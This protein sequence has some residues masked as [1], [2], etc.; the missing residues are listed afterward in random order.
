MAEW[1]AR[2]KAQYGKGKTRQVVNRAIRAES[3]G[4]DETL[5]AL[6]HFS[7]MSV[8]LRSQRREGVANIQQMV[9][10]VGVVL[11]RLNAIRDEM[12]ESIK[13]KYEHV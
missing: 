2:L 1:H 3:P 6:E 10:I 8:S 9:D 4:G 13:R 11:D 12:A 5:D 7:Q